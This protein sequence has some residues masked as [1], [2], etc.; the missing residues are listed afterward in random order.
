MVDSYYCLA[1]KFLNSIKNRFTVKK[2]D[3]RKFTNA[4]PLCGRCARIF[5][6]DLY[7]HGTWGPVTLFTKLKTS[8]PVLRNALQTRPLHWSS[9]LFT[10]HFSLHWRGFFLN[11]GQLFKV[12]RFLSNLQGWSIQGVSLYWWRGEADNCEMPK[13]R[14]RTIQI[15]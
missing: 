12:F 7:S 4:T 5:E 15:L 3:L 6:L 1:R 14:F 13:S 10:L 8:P 9:F 2:L 11:S